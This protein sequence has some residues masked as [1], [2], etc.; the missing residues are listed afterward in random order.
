MPCARRLPRS[1]PSPFI[2]ATESSYAT[3]VTAAATSS[4]S[5]AR[6]SELESETQP[7]NFSMTSRLAS[8]LPRARL[9]PIDVCGKRLSRPGSRRRRG[10]D[11]RHRAQPEHAVGGA[12]APCCHCPELAAAAALLVA[13]AGVRSDWMSCIPFFTSSGR[14]GSR[15]WSWS[16]ARCRRP[17]C[18]CRRR[19]RRR[20]SVRRACRGLS[21]RRRISPG[22]GAAGLEKRCSGKFFG[23]PQLTAKGSEA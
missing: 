18:R 8:W 21:S 17:C 9:F 23:E 13:V 16:S 12:P 1:Q 2:T 14:L 11:R 20:S 22:L 4:F 7:N 10:C 6:R 19:C 15:R 5:S 3:D